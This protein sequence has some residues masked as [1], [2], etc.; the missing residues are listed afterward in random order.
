M[1]SEAGRL[2]WRP[3]QSRAL[4]LSREAH[5]RS[6]SSGSEEHELRSPPDLGLNPCIPLSGGVPELVTL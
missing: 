1:E 3:C 2:P 4:P 5:S 6:G